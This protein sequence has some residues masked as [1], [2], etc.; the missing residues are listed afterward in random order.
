MYINYFNNLDVCLC[1]L[2]AV[3][4]LMYLEVVKGECCSAAFA[5]VLSMRS[6]PFVI[7]RMLSRL[8]GFACRCSVVPNLR[9][10]LVSAVDIFW[11]PAL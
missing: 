6:M 8:T 9:K 5:W 4:L 7:L 3:P 1:F 10:H 11:K 2:L